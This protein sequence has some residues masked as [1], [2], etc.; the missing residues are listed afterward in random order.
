MPQDMQAGRAIGGEVHEIGRRPAPAPPDVSALP[1][2]TQPLLACVGSISRLDLRRKLTATF[3][4]DR[5]II[6]QPF[7]IS[8][9][10]RIKN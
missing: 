6:S 8:D 7:A 9:F 3:C 2:L 1:G 5:G 4:K 10:Y